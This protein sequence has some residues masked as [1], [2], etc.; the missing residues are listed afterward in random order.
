[1]A[2]IMRKQTCAK[3]SKGG[4][5]AMC[6]GCQQSFCIKHFV[7]HRQ[8]LSQLMDDI[9][10][11]HDL[12]RRDMNYE[13]STQSLLTRIDQWEQE[14]I[15]KIQATA[16]KARIDL[17]QLLDQTKNELKMSVNRLTEEL[18]TCR[19]SDDYTEIDIK[20]WTEQLKELRQMIENPSSINIGCENNATS[21]ISLIKVSSLQQPLLSSN[22]RNRLNE[23]DSR[24]SEQYV[25]PFSEKFA[26][27]YG[28]ITLSADGLTG[29]CSSSRLDGSYISGIGHYSSKVHQIRFRI[30]NKTSNYLFFGIITASQKLGSSIT[31]VK[32]AYGW[33]ELG[34]TISN[35]KTKVTNQT[36]IISSGDEITLILDCDHRHI[37]LKHH[38][39]NSLVDIPIDLD[40]C[41]FPWKIVLRL[42]SEH[43]CIKILQ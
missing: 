43:D 1:M 10:Q 8:E 5:I 27:V 23:I 11:E 30:E 33:W 6:N 19:E 18:R 40:Q 4:G 7:E 25:A 2:S 31:A 24:I 29:Y 22:Q 42:D 39:T 14:S 38:Q 13:K 36:K 9:G 17:Q 21:A 37:Q 12:L 15:K 41:P 35:G 28:N 26:E 34:F 20:K 16:N 32:S 3:C